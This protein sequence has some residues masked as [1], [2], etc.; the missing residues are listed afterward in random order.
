M[1]APTRRSSKSARVTD[2]GV[3]GDVDELYTYAYQNAGSA[4][5]GGD[6]EDVVYVLSIDEYIP[7]PFV[8]PEQ[9]DAAQLEAADDKLVQAIGAR[10]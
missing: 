3:D 1:E 7:P 4:S 2:G 9:H 5:G 10:E 6:P 8:A